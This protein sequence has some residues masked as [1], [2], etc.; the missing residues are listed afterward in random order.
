MLQQHFWQQ[1]PEQHPP[2]MQQSVSASVGIVETLT[3]NEV[4]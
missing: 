4:I 3:E 1:Q 2:G